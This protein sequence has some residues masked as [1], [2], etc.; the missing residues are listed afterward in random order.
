MKRKPDSGRERWT[1]GAKTTGCSAWDRSQGSRAMDL[2]CAAHHL[3]E[4][5]NLIPAN[6]ARRAN[7]S[8]AMLTGIMC[9]TIERVGT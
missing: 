8:S 7:I 2:G 9:A 3:R 4:K 1:P 6:V 5:Q